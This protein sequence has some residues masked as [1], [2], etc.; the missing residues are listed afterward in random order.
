MKKKIIFL[1][2]NLFSIRDYERLGINFLT[3]DFVVKIISV[4]NITNKRF[5]KNTGKSKNKFKEFEIIRSYGDLE[6]LLEINFFDYA[7]DFM[8]ITLNSWKIRKLLKKKEIKL[9]KNF[10]NDAS[11]PTSQNKNIFKRIFDN[12]F[13]RK[14]LGGSI[15]KKLI[16]RILLSINRNFI[17]DYG[18]F[19]NNKAINPSNKKKCVNIIRSHTFDYDSFLK[20]KHQKP[21]LNYKNYYVFIDNNLSSHPDYKY[22][23]TRPPVIK[24]KYFLDLN[25]FFDKFEK[26]TN[27]KI[28]IAANPKTIY[29]NVKIFGGRK[30]FN[31]QTPILIKGS[32]GVLMHNS[33]AVNFAVMYKKPILFLTSN[34]INESWLS[35]GITLLA[36]SLKLN[37]INID[38]NYQKSLFGIKFSHKAYDSFLNSYIKST[39]I[40]NN[41]SWKILKDK[42]L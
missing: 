4:S 33:T 8:G 34:H 3:K 35:E 38:N 15:L 26:I 2:D 42:L 28:L 13:P 22:H 1:T 18:V 31:N 23:G 20:I 6:K 29:T 7:Y 40:T 25:L 30:I 19:F 5:S 39:N 9:I 10:A 32:S 41:F 24:E 12:F 37:V 21:L 36:R 14:Q 27:S 11:I 17:W 16:N